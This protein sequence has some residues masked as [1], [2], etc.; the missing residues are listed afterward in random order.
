M[1][2]ATRWSNR[3][4]TTLC[5]RSS[6]ADNPLDLLET[7]SHEFF[8]VW[9]VERLRPGSLEPFDFSRANPSGELWFAEG[10][11]NYYDGLTLC[12]SGIWSLDRYAKDLTETVETLRAS[13]APRHGS[14]VD[15]SLQAPFR[16]R[17]TWID[18]QNS[19]NTFLSYYF[20]GDAVALALD[21]MLR[22]ETQVSLDRY[23]QALWR[24]FGRAER[25]Y[26]NRDLELTLAKVTGDESFAKGFFRRYVHGRE[27]ADYRSLLANAGLLVRLARPGAPSWGPVRL[28]ARDGAV[29]IDSAPLEGSP[30]YEAD[31]TRG[32]RILTIDGREIS[33]A[34]D[35]EAILATKVPGDTISI[36]Y[37]Q[38]LER[39]TANV[40]LIQDPVLE[41]V[42]FEHADLP[43][44][45]AMQTFRDDWLGSKAHGNVVRP[46]RRCATCMR[47]FPLD[48]EFCPYDG[49]RLE[50][51]AAAR[52]EASNP[53]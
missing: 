53:P 44:D 1:P 50:F 30:L 38:R 8:H 28:A 35:A 4:S 20:Y 26:T 42:P 39:R 15:M 6:L 3:N 47:T 49:E 18:P 41:V 10:F 7:L 32:D 48:A 5:S 43:L 51:R 24:R 9:N 12:R 34:A 13:P 52:E 29:R 16:D 45:A 46:S 11:T 19:R 36:D 17:A 33:E 40:E 27:L 2:T 22:S 23:M 21:L 14:P 37:E 31:L 25:P